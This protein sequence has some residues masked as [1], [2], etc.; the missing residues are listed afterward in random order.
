MKN[1]DFFRSIFNIH[2][3]LLLVALFLT[4]HILSFPVTAIAQHPEKGPGA[5]IA[6]DSLHVVERST[7]SLLKTDSVRF[8]IMAQEQRELASRKQVASQREID[9]TNDGKPEVLRLTGY[10]AKDI[11]QTKLTFTIKSG[12]KLLW[13]DH[14]TAGGYFDTID[15]L[16]DSVKLRRMRQ[17][18]TIAFANENFLVI[19]SADF[20]DLFKHVSQADLDPNSEE[21]HELF[22]EPRVMFSVFHSR[23]YWYGLV[24]DPKLKKFLRVWRN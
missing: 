5:G 14:W 2:C 8:A 20:A 6:V 19:D 3:P 24:W 17:I 16:T 15:H 22:R 4:L 10:P 21:A 18:V 1:G 7:D 23:D 9:L 12:G 11:D 13:E